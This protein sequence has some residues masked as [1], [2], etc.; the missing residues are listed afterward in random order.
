MIVIELDLNQNVNVLVC[1]F[2]YISSLLSTLKLVVFIAY[3][4]HFRS[5]R[6]SRL[7]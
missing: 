6:Q 3:S 5:G 7:C 1:Y 4:L 2:S